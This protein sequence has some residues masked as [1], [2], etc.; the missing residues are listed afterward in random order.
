MVWYCGMV[1]EQGGRRTYRVAP[2]EEKAVEH[3]LAERL[4]GG[5]GSSDSGRT[6]LVVLISNKSHYF[7]WEQKVSCAS[8]HTISPVS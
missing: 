5:C 8:F 3:S 6:Y 4:G 7:G 1:W 2:F